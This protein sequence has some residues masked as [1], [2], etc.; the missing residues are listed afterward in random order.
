MGGLVVISYNYILYRIKRYFGLK[1]GKTRTK[2]KTLRFVKSLYLYLSSAGGENN[3]KG[4]SITLEELYDR[5]IEIIDWNLS[6]N[7]EEISKDRVWYFFELQMDY[8]KF[9]RTTNT[10]FIYLNEEDHFKK[11]EII[12][13]RIRDFSL[14]EDYFTFKEFQVFINGYKTSYL[15]IAEIDKFR[16]V[17]KIP[18]RFKKRKKII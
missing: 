18:K 17:G 5:Y 2:I 13:E 6:F 4:N 7:K 11:M 10:S 15:H 12:L 3:S 16:N 14:E 9:L 1:E 8:L